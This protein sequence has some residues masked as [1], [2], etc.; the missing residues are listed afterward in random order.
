MKNPLLNLSLL[1]LVFLCSLPREAK[2]RSG[3]VPIEA[4]RGLKSGSLPITLFAYDI[5]NAVHPHKKS[6]TNEELVCLRKQKFELD[7]AVAEHEELDEFKKLKIS[8]IIMSFSSVKNF[9]DLKELKDLDTD[10]SV[11]P[12]MN[13]TNSNDQES[14]VNKYVLRVNVVFNRNLPRPQNCK[15]IPEGNIHNL[16]SDLKDLKS[17]NSAKVAPIAP[18]STSSKSGNSGAGR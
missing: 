7:A 17:S 1:S 4:L 18:A 15:A 2:K 10:V 8:R 13:T 9:S 3:D 12:I 16:L 6:I 14:I 5:G 11:L